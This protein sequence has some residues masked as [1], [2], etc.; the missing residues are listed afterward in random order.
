MFIANED[1][2]YGFNDKN[3]QDWAHQIK[4]DERIPA[5]QNFT[6][7]QVEDLNRQWIDE[8]MPRGKGGKSG[9]GGKFRGPRGLKCLGILGLIGITLDAIEAQILSAECKKNPCE[10][11]ADDCT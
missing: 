2:W 4:Q 7:K 11:N 10:C 6:R 3:F 9:M 8:G 5:N 1:N